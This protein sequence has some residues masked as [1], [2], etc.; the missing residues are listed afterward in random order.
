MTL[1][2]WIKS[3]FSKLFGAKPAAYVL[4][5][6][7]WEYY[8]NPWD[9]GDGAPDNPSERRTW[10]LKLFEM[11]MRP[12]I[13]PLIENIVDGTVVRSDWALLSREQ[14]I[15]CVAEL[16]AWLS[17]YESSWKPSTRAPGVNPQDNALG[18]F[19]MGF[20]DQ[21]GW[22]TGTKYT[23]EQ[24]LTAIPNI[25]TAVLILK[26]QLTRKKRLLIHKTAGG[27]GV[28]GIFWAPI[29]VGGKYDNH[30]AILQH[31]KAF[32]PGAKSQTV[33]SLSDARTPP[34]WY[35]EAKKYSGKKETD[36]AF[37]AEMS[38]KWALF[39]MNL[40]TIKES[41]AAWCGL[42]MAAVLAGVG[43]KYQSDGEMARNWGKFGVPI[44]WK[45]AGIP[46]GAVIWINHNSNCSASSSN[47][48]TQADG[49]CA[50]ADLT[51]PGATFNGYGGNQDNTWKVS[52]Y[53]V[54][55]IC[56]VRWPSDYPMPPKLTK[57]DRCTS[58]S[59]GS[60]S[61]R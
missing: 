40:G 45:T 35:V 48:V 46:R 10:S 56:A 30:Q 43:L 39:G 44:E 51:K 5:K 7:G 57:S 53:P 22:N 28:D 1:W 29:Y 19:Q 11:M 41:W 36:P 31:V 42:A 37:N 52:T 54:A 20:R 58:G 3:F 14:K 12:D 8:Q 59:S 49:D 2:D 50:P 16:F 21:A 27:V 61:T 6:L 18:L 26:T 4:P 60:E 9:Y 33:T 38:K 23:I 47:H 55:D 32:D 24:L 34:P 17:K 13:A 25:E 15:A